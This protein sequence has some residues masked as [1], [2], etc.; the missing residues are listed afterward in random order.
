MSD[1]PE[2]PEKPVVEKPEKP[3]VVPPAPKARGFFVA[4]G[5]S[6]CCLNN[7]IVGP[8][9]QITLEQLSSD[10]E[11]AKVAMDALLKRGSVVKK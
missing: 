10:P 9:Q 1:K 3:A 4:E 8:D 6:V 5:K 7:M 2:T 11:I